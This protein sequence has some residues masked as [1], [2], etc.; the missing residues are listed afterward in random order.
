MFHRLFLSLRAKQRFRAVELRLSERRHEKR[1]LTGF[2]CSPSGGAAVNANFPQIEPLTLS[3]GKERTVS[4]H[5][6][7]IVFRADLQNQPVG[8]ELA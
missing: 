7:F 5:Q 4:N 2:G 6:L 8:R 3:H 1:E